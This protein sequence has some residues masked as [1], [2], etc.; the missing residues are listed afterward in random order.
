MSTTHK[1][2]VAEQKRKREEVRQTKERNERLAA[3]NRLRLDIST[4]L[5]PAMVKLGRSAE[6][7]AAMAVR[8][9]DCLLQEVHKGGK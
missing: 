2:Q 4:Q 7:A 3:L 6:K 5:L 8:Y 9:G 1:D